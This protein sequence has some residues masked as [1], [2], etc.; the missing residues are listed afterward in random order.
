M[1]IWLPE[2][3]ILTRLVTLLDPK[4]FVSLKIGQANLD[5]HK[6]SSLNYQSY[7]VPLGELEGLRPQPQVIKM[8]KKGFLIYNNF[9][10]LLSSC[11]DTSAQGLIAFHTK[12]IKSVPN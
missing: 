11:K 9:L 4:C 10:N 3:P 1:H 5:Q 8:F 2:H 12:C 6:T 7:D